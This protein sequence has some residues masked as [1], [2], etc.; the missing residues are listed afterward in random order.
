MKSKILF[1]DGEH[2][3]EAS[4]F[5]SDSFPRAFPPL[6]IPL[7][8][9]EFFHCHQPLGWKVSECVLGGWRRE[10]RR[11]LCVIPEHER[12]SCIWVIQVNIHRLIT[13]FGC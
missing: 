10:G 11:G 8:T 1:S 3:R 5:N 2:S 12:T 13:C 7:I 9:P 4:V 6:P